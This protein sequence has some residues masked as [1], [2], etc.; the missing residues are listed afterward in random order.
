MVSMYLC[1]YLTFVLFQQTG[2]TY[3]WQFTVFGFIAP[4]ILFIV[5]LKLKIIS[6]PDASDR[7]ERTIPFIIT[8]V[9][10]LV[11]LMFNFNYGV[12]WDLT[13]LTI[14]Y[15]ATTIVILLINLFWKISAHAM[16]VAH[17][18]GVLVGLGADL[19]WVGVPV[20]ILLAWA[21]LY[22]KRHTPMQ[23]VAGTIVGFS[24]GFFIYRLW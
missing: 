6:D 11:L 14:S 15:L 16:T 19:W 2:N 23:V 4:V 22:L 13:Q 3:F 9:L 8:L 24:I 17:S 1:S 7:K 10:L 5:F 21:R 12:K 20:L 18:I